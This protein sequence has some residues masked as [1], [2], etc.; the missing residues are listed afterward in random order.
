M[1]QLCSAIK[2]IETDLGHLTY[3]LK[4]T[5][6]LPKTCKMCAKFTN[7]FDV[8]HGQSTPNGPSRAAIKQGNPLTQ[9]DFGRCA[10]IS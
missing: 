8:K 1:C 4:H 9:G 7:K 2:P 6:N 3:K 10:P 5:V